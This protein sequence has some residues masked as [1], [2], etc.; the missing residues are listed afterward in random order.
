MGLIKE[1]IAFGTRR[2]LLDRLVSTGKER[3][4]RLSNTKFCNEFVRAP[5]LD[6]ILDVKFV[7]EGV[8]LE[9]E[10][11][12]D[13]RNVILKA[14]ALVKKSLIGETLDNG[15]VN[16]RINLSATDNGSVNLQ[17]SDLN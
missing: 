17:S 15:T 6:I 13:N 1:K 11:E 10:N 5:V 4:L 12:L 7:T 8:P 9:P 2:L 14:I 3:R 16:E